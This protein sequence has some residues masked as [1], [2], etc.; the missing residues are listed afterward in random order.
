MN[1][2]KQIAND[3]IALLKERLK[4]RK[5]LNSLQGMLEQEVA[6]LSAPFQSKLSALNELIEEAEQAI[7]DRKKIASSEDADL[8]QSLETNRALFSLAPAALDSLLLQ[9]FIL[10]MKIAEVVDN[11]SVVQNFRQSIALTKIRYGFTD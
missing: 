6:G 10:Q 4:G 5:S 2:P 11:D 8:K 1:T 9:K 3:G 7:S